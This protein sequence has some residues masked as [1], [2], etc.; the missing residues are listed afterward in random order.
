MLNVSEDIT[1]I[2]IAIILCIISV[3]GLCYLAI[4]EAGVRETVNKCRKRVFAPKGIPR[5]TKDWARDGLNIYKKYPMHRRWTLDWHITELRRY[6]SKRSAGVYND[7]IVVKLNKINDQHSSVFLN[8]SRT[9][10]GLVRDSFIVVDNWPSRGDEAE[11]IKFQSRA[12]C[13]DLMAFFALMLQDIPRNDHGEEN[14]QDSWYAE[15]ITWALDNIATNGGNAQLINGTT[16]MSTE[17][18][19]QDIALNKVLEGYNSDRL[20]L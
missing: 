17:L 6:R 13:P 2:A 18:S 19:G 14:K 4:R 7:N 3:L 15:L 16:T 9:P 5:A 8:I 12:W 20:I 10:L 11:R 1:A